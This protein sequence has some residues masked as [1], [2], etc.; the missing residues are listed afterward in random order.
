MQSALRCSGARPDLIGF[1]LTETAIL[2]HGKS[3]E[4]TLNALKDQGIWLELDDFG[5]GFSSLVA[6]RSYQIDALKID[7]LFVHNLERTSND[8]AIVRGVIAMGH[9]L[10]M[11]VVGEGVES[12]SEAALLTELG[13]DSLQGFYFARPVPVEQLI[14]PLP[15]P[16]ARAA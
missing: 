2:K 14:L 1:E 12:A 6:L 15:V 16:L 10:N 5:T 11:A 13:C 3:A 9:A 8:A 4:R 7:R